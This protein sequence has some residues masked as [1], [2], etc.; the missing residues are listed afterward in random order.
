MRNPIRVKGDSVKKTKRILSIVCLAAVLLSFTGTGAHAAGGISDITNDSI[1]QKKD[2]ISKSKDEKKAL[3]SNLSDAKAMKKELEGLRNDTAAYITK[4][5][6]QISEV[7]ENIE[8]YKV[9]IEEKEQEIVEM[10]Q[11]LEQAIAVQDAQYEA[12]KARIRFMYERGDTFYLELMFESKS[13][14]DLLTKANYI[15]RLTTYDRNKLEEY[16]QVTEWTKLCKETLEAEK[17][18]LDEAKASLEAEE[19]S[20]QELMHDKEVQLTSYKQQI[21]SKEED[22]AAYEAEIA[23]RDQLIQQLETA[24][25]EE[26][27]EIARKMGIALTYDGSKFTWPAP[28]YVAITSDFGYRTDPFTGRTSYH[29]GID[30][31]SGSGTP[32]L[33][34]FDGIVAAAGSDWS[35]GNYIMINH[36]G[37]LYTVYMHSSKLLVKK[38]DVVKRGEKIAL[39]GTTGRSTG[40]HLHF[41]VRLNGQYVSP[42]PYLKT[43]VKQ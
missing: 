14:G 22:I 37:G 18:V 6:G 34:A 17:E 7:Q 1:K 40:N 24:I 10:T 8:D 35:M 15:E 19:A 13:F 26:Q 5:D 27:K 36:G 2:Q 31:A 11:E 42:W 30:M 43:G 4:I 28:S 25:T 20:L 9:K 38:D 41:S 23:A 12:M 29:S 16:K 3:Q 32:I 33:A 39:V 21:M